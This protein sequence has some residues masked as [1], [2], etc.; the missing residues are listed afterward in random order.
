MQAQNYSSRSAVC[1]LN[2]KSGRAD[3]YKLFFLLRSGNSS[4]LLLECFYPEDGSSV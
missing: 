3:Y 2:A 1:E 4:H